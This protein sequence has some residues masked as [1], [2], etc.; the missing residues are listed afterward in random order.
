MHLLA[1]NGTKVPVTVKMSQKE[2]VATGHM[3][4]VVQVHSQRGHILHAMSCRTVFCGRLVSAACCCRCQQQVH[5][6]ARRGCSTG[7]NWHSCN[8][9]HVLTVNT[10][11]L[12]VACRSAKP[13][14][15]SAWTTSA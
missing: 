3:T 5:A 15:S 6:G 12:G 10:V 4:H 1:A 2:D 7:V 11:L 13:A 9:G 14:R 8:M